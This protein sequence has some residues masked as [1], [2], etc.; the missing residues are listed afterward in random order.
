[1]RCVP[2][3]LCVW[4][5]SR[6]IDPYVPVVGVDAH[7]RASTSA[8]TTV[9]PVTGGNRST[10][11]QHITSRE[12]FY[13]KLIWVVDGT[14]RKRDRAQLTN[15]WNDGVSV[16]KSSLVRQAF[17]GDCGLL[18]EWAG[19]N[20]PIFFD[21]G[22]TERLWWLLAKSN[23]VWAYVAQFPRAQ[24]IEWHRSTATEMARQ[25]EKLVNDIPKLIT[26]YESRPRVQPVTWNPLQPPRPRRPF[27][28]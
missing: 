1:M 23:D 16:G 8:S 10:P 22:E 3:G 11:S 12:A 2:R 27:R 4:R 9:A 21:L 26:D 15:A 5:R 14:R 18:E 24:F 6:R 13:P 25:C 17:W 19:S 28:L 7:T 20:A